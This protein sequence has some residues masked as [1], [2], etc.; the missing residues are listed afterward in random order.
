MQMPATMILPATIQAI[1]GR[2][3]QNK[4]ARQTC[5]TG[6]EFLSM[7]HGHDSNYLVPDLTTGII[8]TG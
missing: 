7:P 3:H 4:A 1:H 6:A 8:T 5:R 2:P